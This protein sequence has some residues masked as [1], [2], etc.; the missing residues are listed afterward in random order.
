MHPGS[1]QGER[2]PAD[3]HSLEYVVIYH[4]MKEKTR[5]KI[6]QF[7]NAQKMKSGICA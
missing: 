7:E 3:F 4:E 5:L 2:L 6:I 1:S